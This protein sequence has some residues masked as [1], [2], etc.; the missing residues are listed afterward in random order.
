[1]ALLLELVMKGV[2]LGAHNPQV[3]NGA[4]LVTDVSGAGGLDAKRHP[5]QLHAPEL[6]PTEATKGTLGDVGRF[7]E[8]L[9]FL[10]QG[11]TEPP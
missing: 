5:V 9:C 3:P 10:H 6:V 7:Q 11:N 8:A 4:A 1:M 2:G